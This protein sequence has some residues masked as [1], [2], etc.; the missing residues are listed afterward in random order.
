LCAAKK[1]R[2]NT[3]EIAKWLREELER[4]IPTLVG[5]DHT[6]SFPLAYFEK[7]RLSSNWEGFLLDFQCYWPT[8][9]PNTYVSFISADY[10]GHGLKRTGGWNWLRVTE[11]WTP[12]AKSVIGFGVQG[13]VA[14]STHAG[15]PWFLYLRKRGVDLYTSGRSMAGRFPRANRLW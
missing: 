6:F 2:L 15:L 7:Y 3:Q 12:T 4:G 13:E 9:A 10:S 1:T 8:H 5:I 14:T 11:Q